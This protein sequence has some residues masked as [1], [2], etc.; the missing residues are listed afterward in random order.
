MLLR[1]APERAN[2]VWFHI[3]EV[4]VR[5]FLF[6]DCRRRSVSQVHVR[7]H[8][9]CTESRRKICVVLLTSGIAAIVEP[10]YFPEPPRRA[11]APSWVIARGG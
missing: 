8:C 9:F 10:L 6:V 5:R 11:Q 1:Y 3:V 4:F 7:G 2:I